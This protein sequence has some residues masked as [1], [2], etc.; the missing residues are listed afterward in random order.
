MYIFHLKAEAKKSELLGWGMAEQAGQGIFRLR[1]IRSLYLWRS[2]GPHQAT[3]SIG[4]D[5]QQ[6]KAAVSE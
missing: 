1:D 6:C 4:I 5:C 3:S 2:L